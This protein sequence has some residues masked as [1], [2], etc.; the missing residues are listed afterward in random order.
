M[1][2]CLSH[3]EFSEDS[4][5]IGSFDLLPPTLTMQE[6]VTLLGAFKPCAG[7]GFGT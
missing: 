2:T 3:Q 6:H 7:I 4:V 5:G 1:L